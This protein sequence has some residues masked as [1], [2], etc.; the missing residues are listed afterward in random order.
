[1]EHKPPRFNPSRF[2]DVDYNNIDWRRDSFFVIERIL[3]RGNLADFLA[4]EEFYPVLAITDVV[5]KS[6]QL[7]PRMRAYCMLRYDLKTSDLCIKEPCYP[8]LWRY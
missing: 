6:R 1:M 5:K 2:W 3:Q 8:E 7:D 4:I